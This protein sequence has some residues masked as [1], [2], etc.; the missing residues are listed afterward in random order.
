MTG[1][2]HYAKAEEHLAAAA[3]IETDGYEDSMSAWHQRQAIGH[4][5]LALAA[6]T[7]L[8]GQHPGDWEREIWAFGPEDGTAHDEL[9]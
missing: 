7:A 9:D 6:A 8:P 5:L 3:G 2:A 1:P 4:G